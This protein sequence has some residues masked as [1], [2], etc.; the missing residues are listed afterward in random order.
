M[1]TISRF[2]RPGFH[3]ERLGPLE[4]E[5]LTGHSSLTF[6][7]KM[8]TAMTGTSALCHGE[9]PPGETPAAPTPEQPAATREQAS[10]RTGSIPRAFSAPRTPI[11]QRLLSRDR[12]AAEPGHTDP[13]T[14]TTDPAIPSMRG[15]TIRRESACSWARATRSRSECERC[16][17]TSASTGNDSCSTP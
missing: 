5:C 9:Q 1:W 10:S 17:I 6:A 16:D 12:G 13:F 14:D 8:T 2:T 4:L 11:E 3:G 7:S 15:T